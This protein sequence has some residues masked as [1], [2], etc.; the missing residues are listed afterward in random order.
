[1]IVN[2]LL[3]RS[4]YPPAL[5]SST[6]R[7]QYLETLER[8]QVQGDDKDFITLTAA[9]VEVMLDRYL[10]LLQMTEDADEQLQLKH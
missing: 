5:Y 2:L 8:A 9:A 6:D 4:G 7:V 10:Q 3:M 1:M